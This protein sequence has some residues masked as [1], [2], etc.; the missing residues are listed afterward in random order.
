MLDVG[1]KSSR[2]DA[3]K[4]QSAWLVSIQTAVLALAAFTVGKDRFLEATKIGALAL[5]ALLLSVGCSSSN[6]QMSPTKPN[7]V[8]VLTD[9]KREDDLDGMPLTNALLKDEGVDFDNF[10]ATY[11]LCCPSRSSILTSL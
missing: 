5:L 11:P 4:D 1:S 2:L 9:D 7:I 10:Y 6:A 3:L 8:I